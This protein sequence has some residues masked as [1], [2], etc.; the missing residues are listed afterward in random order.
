MFHRSFPSSDPRSV[1]A[2]L[3]FS[4]PRTHSCH[5]ADSRRQAVDRRP[6]RWKRGRPPGRSAMRGRRYSTSQ[7]PGTVQNQDH[8][9][10]CK[11][12]K[13]KPHACADGLPEEPEHLLPHFQASVCRPIPRYRLEL[14]RFPPAARLVYRQSIEHDQERGVAVDCDLLGADGSANWIIWKRNVGV[15]H[16]LRSTAMDC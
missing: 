13:D 2:K 3:T 6:S 4:W 1:C 14:Q 16:P 15:Q 11:A 10:A 9:A 7:L 8:H 12:K 5:H